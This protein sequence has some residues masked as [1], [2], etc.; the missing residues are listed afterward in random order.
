MS[1]VTCHMY[2][3]QPYDFQIIWHTQS[4]LSSKKLR[5]N[6]PLFCFTV[7]RGGGLLFKVGNLQ[8][9]YLCLSRLG[10]SLG[11]LQDVRP[12]KFCQAKHPE[13][14]IPASIYR[15]DIELLMTEYHIHLQDIKSSH[16]LTGQNSN[17]RMSSIRLNLLTKNNLEDQNPRRDT[18]I[19][20]VSAG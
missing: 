16:S 14:Q 12:D 17:R 6:D 5:P 1:C 9:F 10:C 18:S 7:Q 15:Q 4:G 2:L 11:K 13:D 19:P 20:S 8:P 3:L